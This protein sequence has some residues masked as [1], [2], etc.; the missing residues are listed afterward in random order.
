MSRRMPDKLMAQL[1]V[2]VVDDAAAD[3]DWEVS[4]QPRPTRLGL[5][6]DPKAYGRKRETT[7]ADR[8]LAN[9]VRDDAKSSSDDEGSRADLGRKKNV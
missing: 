5:G 3:D 7:S 1:M 6:A 2:G 9:M 8:R 4:G